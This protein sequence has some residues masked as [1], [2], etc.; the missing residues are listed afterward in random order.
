M[1][2]LSDKY[3]NPQEQS[4]NEMNVN[5]NAIWKGVP[6]VQCVQVNNKRCK[7][8]GGICDQVG[9]WV[10]KPKGDGNGQVFYGAPVALHACRDCYVKQEL[11]M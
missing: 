4:G 9:G 11:R 2:K 1:G 5:W 3:L 10:K 7:F 8:C 6:A